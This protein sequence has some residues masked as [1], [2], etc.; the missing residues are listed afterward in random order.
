M[1]GWRVADL[2]LAT[3]GPLFT[4]ADAHGAIFFGC[5]FDP[6]TELALR[7][8]GALIFPE[9]PVSRSPPTAARSTNRPSCTTPC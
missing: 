2:D 3:R 1:R 7:A 9:L 8:D 5:A 6:D 4:R